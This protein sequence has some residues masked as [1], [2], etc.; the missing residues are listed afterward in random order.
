MV[1]Q[2]SWNSVINGNKM[3]KLLCFA[4]ILLATR[5]KC[6]SEDKKKKKKKVSQK[7]NVEIFLFT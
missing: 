6:I 5:S 2:N 4:P 1:V 3:T 7:T